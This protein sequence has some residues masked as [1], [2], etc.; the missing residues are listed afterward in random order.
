MSP[1][2]LNIS[3]ADM[4][5][6]HDGRDIVIQLLVSKSSN[7]ERR[8]TSEALTKIQGVRSQRGRA[9][10]GQCLTRKRGLFQPVCICSL[11][12]CCDTNTSC[13][14]SFPGKLPSLLAAE[15]WEEEVVMDGSQSQGDCLVKSNDNITGPACQPHTIPTPCYK[16][17]ERPYTFKE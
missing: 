12:P 10:W 17:K 8:S 5:D 4:W 15:A 3:K 2:R 7:M 13:A 11:R 1:K 6:Y 9:R 16:W 14:S